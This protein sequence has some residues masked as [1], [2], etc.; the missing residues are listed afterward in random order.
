[1]QLAKNLY[2]TK[3]KTLS[4]KIKEAYLTYRIEQ[5]LS[6]NRILELYLNIAEWGPGIY[7]IGQASK[8]Y[9]G[10]SPA[11]LDLN[12]AS[13]LA[14][15]LPNPRYY[16]P[17][18]SMARVEKRHKYLLMRMLMEHD[19]QDLEYEVAVSMPVELRDI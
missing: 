17:F 10:K 15:I 14:V 11:E 8:Y 1:M 19:I 3:E 12:E 13:L 7:G 16:N 2:L 9:F 5:M 6:K 4:R 18:T